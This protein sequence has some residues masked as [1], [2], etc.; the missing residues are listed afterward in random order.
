ME[1]LKREYRRLKDQ[2]VNVGE[3][4]SYDEVMWNDG[5][6]IAMDELLEEVN[7]DVKKQIRLNL[8]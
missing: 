2:L 1:E 5:I 4:T 7:D 8:I 6:L 3:E